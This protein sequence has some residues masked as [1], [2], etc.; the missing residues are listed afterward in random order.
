MSKLQELK[1]K[2]NLGKG[3]QYEPKTDCKF[4]N[5]TGE[6][7]NNRFCICLYVSPELSE[8]AGETLAKTAKKLM[9]EF[10]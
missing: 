2:Y 8:F 6:R 9:E 3:A 5:G 1:Q 7:P 10:N 4:C